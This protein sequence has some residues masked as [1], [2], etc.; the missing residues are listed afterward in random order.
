MRWPWQKDKD[1][2]SRRGKPIEPRANT[3]PAKVIG[4]YATLHTDHGDFNSEPP[5]YIY[6][7]CELIIFHLKVVGAVGRAHSSTLHLGVINVTTDIV[8]PARVPQGSEDAFTVVQAV[9]MQWMKPT[10]GSIPDW[11]DG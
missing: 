7:D 9:A 4:V 8:P 3:I 1:Q 6:I 5:G 11:H 10:G 2:P